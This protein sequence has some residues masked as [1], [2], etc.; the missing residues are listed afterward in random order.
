M[1]KLIKVYHSYINKNC[2]DFSVFS[3]GS[4]IWTHL[5]N[6]LKTSVPSKVE[7]QSLLSEKDLVK[8]FNSDVR[9]YSNNFE[10]SLY[11]DDY[12]LGPYY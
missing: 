3:V 8:K 6:L 7:I 12:N 4:F 2:I 1:K 5:N 10:S 11:F 9:K